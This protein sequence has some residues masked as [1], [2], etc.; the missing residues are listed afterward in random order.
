MP[1]L[2]PVLKDYV[3][4]DNKSTIYIRIIQ[5]GKPGYLKTEYR[6]EPHYFKNGKT[7]ASYPLQSKLN[8]ALYSILLE[9]E[10]LILDMTDISKIDIKTLVSRLKGKDDA[11]FV[12]FTTKLIAELREQKR[13]SYL[14]SFEVMLKHL[15]DYTGETLS[16]R[17][18]NT[19]F[20]NGFYTYLTKTVKNINSIRLYF[21]RLKTV[22][23]Q[24][25]DRGTINSDL[26]FLR[27]FRVRGQKTEKRSISVNELRR[28]RI[29]P[30]PEAQEKA[31]TIFFLMFYLQ[32]MNLKDLLYLKNEQVYDGRIHYNRSKTKV[33]FSI[34][35][36][37]QCNNI[38]AK[39]KGNKY[40]LNLLDQND[41]Y[42]YY[43]HVR[44]NLNRQLK[45]AYG[46]QI[47][48]YSARHTVASLMAELDIPIET[49]SQTLGHS[50]GAKMTQTYI[51]FNYVK[52]DDAMEKVINYV[53]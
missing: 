33:L 52:V 22:C 31:V 7:I 35:I 53:G 4:S 45:L 39:W 11:D 1:T 30:Y 27:K 5:K 40:L 28:L 36:F 8:K 46:G 12:K 49:I 25:K 48:L 44:N 50:S 10:S 6:I 14:I 51:K 38:I 18:I 16:F 34:K 23:Y 9:Y 26:Q 29:G 3:C 13:Y 32:G 15:K 41:S 19:D 21:E 47:S 24:A 2:K 43:R 20:L 37:P 42:D 17:S